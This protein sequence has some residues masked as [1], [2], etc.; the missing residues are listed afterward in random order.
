M[1]RNQIDK[2]KLSRSRYTL[3]WKK[4]KKKEKMSD[5][6][7]LTIRLYAKVHSRYLALFTE[8]RKAINRGSG[9]VLFPLGRSHVF[10]IRAPA[11]NRGRI[12][13]EASGSTSRT[14]RHV[15]WARDRI[16][17]IALA[18]VVTYHLTKRHSCRDR[19]RRGC[20]TLRTI[21]LHSI[22]NTFVP[23]LQRDTFDAR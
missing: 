10:I 5:E 14:S 2:R 8:H 4:K 11:E 20:K 18:P 3:L 7:E 15:N 1:K 23:R 6:D 22:E 19:H 16:Y 21:R 17:E 12:K 9:S 13:V